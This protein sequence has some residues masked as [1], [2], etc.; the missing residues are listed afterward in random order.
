MYIKLFFLLKIILIFLILGLKVYA[1]D[2]TI[3]PQKKPILDK[4]VKQKII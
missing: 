1:L 4:S 3:V 2:V